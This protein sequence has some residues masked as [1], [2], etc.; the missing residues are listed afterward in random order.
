MGEELSLVFPGG[1]QPWSPC[2]HTKQTGHIRRYTVIPK[3]G[4]V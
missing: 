1:E 3:K 2:A 4:G